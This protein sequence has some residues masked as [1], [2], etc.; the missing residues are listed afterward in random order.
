MIPNSSTPIPQALKLAQAQ[1][2][3]I[4]EILASVP[5]SGLALATHPIGPV[6]PSLEIALSSSTNGSVPPSFAI[7]YVDREVV[8]TNIHIPHVSLEDSML[9]A[10]SS[11]APAD[12]HEKP[13]K[14]NRS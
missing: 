8:A 9:E 12:S 6:V 13:R 11:V 4:D 3:A 10:S 7:K 2:P 1:V 5:I 14:Q